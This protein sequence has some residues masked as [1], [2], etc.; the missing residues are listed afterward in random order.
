MGEQRAAR[1]GSKALDD[2]EIE[3]TDLKAGGKRRQI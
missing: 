3:L 1:V 2:A